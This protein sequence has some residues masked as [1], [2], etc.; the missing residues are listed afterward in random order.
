MFPIQ[1]YLHFHIWQL[2]LFS[3]AVS[4]ILAFVTCCCNQIFYE[5]FWSISFGIRL[6]AI[7]WFW[8][9]IS[10]FAFSWIYSDLLCHLIWLLRSDLETLN[11]RILLCLCVCYLLS[12]C[13][14]HV[15]TSPLPV[16]SCKFWYTR[17]LWPWI[18]SIL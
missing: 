14:T 1:F 5:F 9:I 3:K 2:L 7:R 17:H 15:E 13:F 4:F 6:N 10:S 12:L 16:N 11:A 18:V 8:F